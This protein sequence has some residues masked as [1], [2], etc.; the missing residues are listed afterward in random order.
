MAQAL[1]KLVT[2][3]PTLLR[4]AVTYSK[5][6]PTTFWH[7]AHVEL[8][9]PSPTEISK[10]IKGATNIT[11]RDGFRNGLVATEVM[12]WFYI[13]ECIGK[14][15]LLVTVDKHLYSHLLLFL[16]VLNG[17][18]CLVCVCLYFFYI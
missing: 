9:P 1:Q 18:I 11:V 3:V 17:L 10:A 15:G 8:V 2:K 13:G 14:G 16:N 6:R 4:A 12:R 5:P 7:Y